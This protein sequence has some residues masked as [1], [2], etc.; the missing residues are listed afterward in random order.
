MSKLPKDDNTI[1]QYA[2]YSQWESVIPDELS[3]EDSDFPYPV[4]HN[5]HKIADEKVMPKKGHEDCQFCGY[6]HLTRLWIVK[7]KD[8]KCYSIVGSECWKRW[9]LQHIKSKNVIRDVMYSKVR[10]IFLDNRSQLLTQYWK[11]F[12]D[13]R[14]Y[15]VRQSAYKF[16]YILKHL[17]NDVLTDS[18]RK[19]LKTLQMTFTVLSTGRHTIIPSTDIFEINQDIIDA[20]SLCTDKAVRQRWVY[21]KPNVGVLDDFI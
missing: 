9:S 1:L 13:G 20:C 18:K 15:R 7:T 2:D 19:D 3:W 12:N 16:S 21:A 8:D 10:D 17:T 5:Q 6:Q 4:Y 11:A 14:F